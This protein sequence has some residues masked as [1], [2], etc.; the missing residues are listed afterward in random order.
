[1]DE[2]F[3]IGNQ[4]YVYTLNLFLT[5]GIGF[6]FTIL[7]ILYGRRLKKRDREEDNLR[8]EKEK[9]HEEL[10]GLINNNRDAVVKKLDTFCEVQDKL[11]RQIDDRFYRHGHVVDMDEKIA[12][13]IVLR[14]KA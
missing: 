2:V 1:M 14:N 13:D 12:G 8:A 3:Q 5:A 9:K 11:H 7:A 6:I 10:V 4:I